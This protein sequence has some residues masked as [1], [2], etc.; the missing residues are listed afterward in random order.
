MT[1]TK[2]LF[3]SFFLLSL[4]IELFGQS[5]LSIVDLQVNGLIRNYVV[6]DLD[7]DGRNDVVIS[8]ST[9]DK[10]KSKNRFLAVYFQ[11]SDGFLQ[12]PN[13]VI[14]V[15]DDAVVYDVA[16]VQGD[17]QKEILY[18]NSRGVFY[19]PLIKGLFR[20]E[21]GKLLIEAG[22]I[23]PGPDVFKLEFFNFARAV[24]NSTFDDLLIPIGSTNFLYTRSDTKNRFVQVTEIL[25]GVNVSLISD[26][27]QDA[28]TSTAAGSHTDIIN[29]NNDQ[30]PDIA[31]LFKN[32]IEVFLQTPDGKFNQIP[33]REVNF[34]TG[35][36][37]TSTM[38]KSLKDMNGDGIP[39]VFIERTNYADR[40][41]FKKDFEFFWGTR[42]AKGIAS[43]GNKPDYTASETGIFVKAIT[44][45]FDNDG[46]VDL[47]VMNF[48]IG[49]SNLLGTFISNNIK[50]SCSLFLQRGNTF[51]KSSTYQKDI[52]QEINIRRDYNRDL[53]YNLSADLNGDGFN[54]LISFK[55]DKTIVVYLG[56]SKTYLSASKSF[57]ENVQV[58]ENGKNMSSQKIF[59]KQK[60]DLVIMYDYNDPQ[61]LRNTLKIISK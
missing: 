54:E 40:L 48:D 20:R 16:N 47:A 35:D 8:Y 4:Q 43:F 41:E 30:Y 28:I 18:I 31:F 26:E 24:T 29:Y 19:I 42:D 1:R 44:E 17:N 6:E 2:L 59:S 9:D 52:E 56:N 11:S 50:V 23:F 33:D 60:N 39:D 38:I 36:S 12:E 27:E 32:K 45:D 37:K 51:P 61:S 3:L 55:D 21:S 5:G 10:R 58:P 7:Q 14:Q 49:I 13:Q 46:K 22:D 57:S 53:M 15:D 25:S 34:K